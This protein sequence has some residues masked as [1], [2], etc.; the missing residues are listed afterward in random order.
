MR[1]FAP[2]APCTAVALRPRRPDP[3]AVAAPLAAETDVDPARSRSTSGWALCGPRRLR[4]RSR[5][6]AV[7]RRL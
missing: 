1:S 7:A 5:P 2:S 3:F 6:A 4:S